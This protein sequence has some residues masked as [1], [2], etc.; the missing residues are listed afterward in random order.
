[1]AKRVLRAWFKILVYS[2]VLV[3]AGIGTFDMYGHIAPIGVVWISILYIVYIM[4]SIYNGLQ[5]TLFHV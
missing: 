5:L 4:C 1:M 2:D 3:F